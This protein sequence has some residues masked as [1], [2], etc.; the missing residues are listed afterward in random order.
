MAS[1]SPQQSIQVLNRAVQLLDLIAQHGTVSLSM[2]VSTASLPPSTVSRILDSLVGHQLVEKDGQTKSYSLGVHL[3]AL[4]QF[5]KRRQKLTA[6]ASPILQ[7]LAEE[8]REDVGLTILQHG[9]AVFVDWVEGPEP[10]KI[11]DRIGGPE[12]LYYGAF[13][14]VLLAHQSQ[15]WID[16]YISHLK[17]EKFTSSTITNEHE[18]YAELQRIQQQGYAVSLGEKVRDAAGIA[19]PVFE[20]GNV[21]R[22]SLTI[23]GPMTRYT[24]DRIPLLAA[25]VVRAADDLTCR[26]GGKIRVSRRPPAHGP[27]TR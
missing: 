22:A 27:T 11:V 12:G 10:L 4:G 26:L 13:R 7:A 2:L 23:V 15:A 24:P 18:L 16:E 19:A 3:G 8:T 20:P 21:I 17:F 6:I 14:K 1:F 9:H 25:S 5:A